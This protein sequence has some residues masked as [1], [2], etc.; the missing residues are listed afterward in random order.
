VSDRLALIE[1]KLDIL[2]WMSGNIDQCPNCNEKVNALNFKKCPHCD[3]NFIT[4]HKLNDGDRS[5]LGRVK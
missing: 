3:Y 1:E 5:F 4:F 2:N